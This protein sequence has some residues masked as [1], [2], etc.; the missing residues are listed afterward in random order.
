MGLV[1]NKGGLLL[2]FSLY[3]KTFAFINCHLKSGADKG[4]KRSKMMATILQN[5]GIGK[6][7]ITPDAT[8]DYAVILG[9]LNYRLKSTFLQ[10]IKNVDNSKNLLAELDELYEAKSH[11]RYPGYKEMPIKFNP[12]YKR[13]S[14]SNL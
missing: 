6:D 13:E 2:Q 4:S 11:Y 3:D 10:H 5:I 7:S 12:T 9:D 1:G 8:A 14:F